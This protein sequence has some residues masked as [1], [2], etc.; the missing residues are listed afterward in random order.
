MNEDVKVVCEE[1]G[2]TDWLSSFFSATNFMSAAQATVVRAF[3]LGT[4]AWALWLD[5]DHRKVRIR[6]YDVRMVI[7]LTW[8]EDDMPRGEYVAWKD[9]FKA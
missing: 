7:P 6:H 9:S 8:D 1:Q 2:A 5:L 3:G 4:G